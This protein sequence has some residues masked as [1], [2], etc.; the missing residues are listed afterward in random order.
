[1]FNWT[2]YYNFFEGEL[3]NKVES[4]HTEK[5]FDY[6]I[7]FIFILICYNIKVGDILILVLNLNIWNSRKE[8][9]RLLEMVVIVDGWR[10]L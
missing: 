5:E 3:I 10:W 8:S 7:L 9:N 2:F 1:M 6:I 4:E